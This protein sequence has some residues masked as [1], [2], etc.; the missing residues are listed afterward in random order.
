MIEKI[1]KISDVEWELKEGFMP[2][3]SVPA[4]IY[5][6]ELLAQTLEEGAVKQL[7]NVATLPGILKY[8]LAMPDVH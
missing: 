1:N 5:I 3:M 2:N 6:S 7:A 4:R 8:S